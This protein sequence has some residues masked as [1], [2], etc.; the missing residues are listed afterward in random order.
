MYNIPCK[1]IVSQFPNINF[2]FFFFFFFFY[3]SIQGK[4][5]GFEL[6]TIASLG[7]VH[8][9]LSYPLGAFYFK[10]YYKNL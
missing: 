2:T 1:T 9:R 6:V 10:N 5:E 3:I 4:G 7:V 8:S